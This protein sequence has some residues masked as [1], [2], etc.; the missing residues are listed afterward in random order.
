[1]VYYETIAVYD[2]QESNCAIAFAILKSAIFSW[3]SC[4]ILSDV[5]VLTPS[6]LCVY[7]LLVG[8]VFFVLFW[9]R[10][11]H[12][13]PFPLP[14]SSATCWCPVQDMFPVLSVY[15]KIS[16]VVLFV[17]FSPPCQFWVSSAFLARAFWLLPAWTRT[18]PAAHSW[19]SFRCGILPPL[20]PLL[21]SH[22]LSPSLRTT[23]P[24]KILLSGLPPPSHSFISPWVYQADI[25][26][27]RVSG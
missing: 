20:D 5:G 2:R 27:W 13:Y 17:S 1:M 26:A 6:I 19:D 14:P 23:V 9:W 18:E 25:A 24:S 22:S 3:Y 10:Q 4:E 7:R 8:W 21:Q 16:G 15:L 11:K 12:S